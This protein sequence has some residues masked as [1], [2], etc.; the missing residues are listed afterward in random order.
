MS[1]FTSASKFAFP[2][3]VAA[4]SNDFD[5]SPLAGRSNSKKIGGMTGSAGFGAGGFGATGMPH[6]IPCGT[7]G[8][9]QH[10]PSR[11]GFDGGR[12]VGSIGGTSLLLTHF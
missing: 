11:F 5:D 12:H 6:T 3:F 9:K 10:L 1:V 7:S 2:S 4:L 8:G